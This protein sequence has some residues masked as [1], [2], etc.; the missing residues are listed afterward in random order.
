[1]NVNVR[2]TG[3]HVE[4]EPSS[5]Y[6]AFSCELEAAAYPMWSLISHLKNPTHAPLAKKLIKKCIE[7]LQDWLDAIN[8]MHPRIEKVS[9]ARVNNRQFLTV[10]FRHPTQNELK[11]A[12]FHYPLHRYL[13][14]LVSQSVKTMGINMSDVLPSTELLTLLM[15]HPLR[16]QVSVVF[17]IFREL[18]SFCDVSG[19]KNTDLLY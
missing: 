18:G 16:V 6:A 2:E 7:S 8:F 13:A 17:N 9:H 14:A 5:Y 4:F 19:E 3:S 12:S 10:F 15:M 11:Y 1:M